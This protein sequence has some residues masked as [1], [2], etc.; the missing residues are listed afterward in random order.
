M[1]GRASVQFE[2]WEGFGTVRERWEGIGRVRER[3]EGFGTV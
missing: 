1:D 3:L 2:R